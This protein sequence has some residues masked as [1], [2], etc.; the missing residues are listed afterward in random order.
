VIA[1][2]ALRSSKSK[3]RDFQRRIEQGYVSFKSK[4]EWLRKRGQI[5]QADEKVMD[6]IREIR[7]EHVHWRPSA[8]RRKLKYFDCALL[9]RKAVQQILMDVQPIV[10]KLRGIS[11]SKETLAVIPSPS[12]FDEVDRT[13]GQLADFPNLDHAR[14]H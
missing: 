14:R 6:A 1:L 12:F 9:T 10:E 8:T 7:N 5:S 13:Y 11:G 2:V 3:D 4:F